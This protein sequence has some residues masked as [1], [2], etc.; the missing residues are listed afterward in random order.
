MFLQRLACKFSVKWIV[1]ET[2]RQ[3]RFLEKY[4]P[5]STRENYH[6][7]LEFFN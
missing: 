2:D 4:T 6:K 3:N 1:R 5:S 7:R